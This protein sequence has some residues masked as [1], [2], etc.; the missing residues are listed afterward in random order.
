MR[1]KTHAGDCRIGASGW[2]YQDWKGIFYPDKLPERE[3]LPF[4]AEQFSTVELNNS[5]YHLPKVR[6]MEHWVDITPKNFLFSVKGSRFI[7]H[8]KKLHVDSSSIQKFFDVIQPLDEAKKLGPI[9]FQLPGRWPLNLERLDEF[10]QLL[11]KK[12]N[13][14]FEF[15]DESWLVPEVFQL[16]TENNIACCI[17]DFKGFLSPAVITADFTY[18]RFHGHRK[19]PY[20]GSYSHQFLAKW[21]KQ[22]QQWQQSGL[23]VYCYFDNTADGSALKNAKQLIQ[24]VESTASAKKIKV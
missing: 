20:V 12:Y 23:D 11:P 9:L 13:Y 4:Y 2:S 8:M 7:T 3:Y 17:Y 5:F 6:T 16:L 18:I 14:T 21:S 22:I 19:T 24:M 10:I 1:H 15:R